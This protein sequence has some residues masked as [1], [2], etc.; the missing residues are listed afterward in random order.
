LYEPLRA[1]IARCTATSALDADVLNLI[2]SGLADRPRAGSGQ[3]IRFC[4]DGPGE[5]GYEQ[6]VFDTGCV[7]TR[8][9]NWHDFFN[10]LVWLRFPRT[11]AALNARHLLGIARQRGAGSTARGALRDA[12]TQFD[13]D[14]IVVVSAEPELAE[15]LRR[16][17]WKSVFWERRAEVG[18]AMRFVVFGHALYD[19]LRQPFRGL[20]GKA[21]FLDADPALLERPLDAQLIEIDTRLAER[22]RDESWYARPSDLAPLPVLGIPGVTPDNADPAYY[23][24]RRQFRPLR[25]PQSPTTPGV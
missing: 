6:T 22:W 24:D 9:D 8:A 3:P 20:C 12:A 25:R 4:A 7:P 14:D 10:G 17:E 15:L 2:V 1:L 11:K 19:K 16:H 21:A 5:A 18:R 13:E 23:D